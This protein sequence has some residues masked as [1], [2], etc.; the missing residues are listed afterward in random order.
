MG[1]IKI[2]HLSHIPKIKNCH[3]NCEKFSFLK[4]KILVLL[5]LFLLVSILHLR[6]NQFLF[7]P[8]ENVGLLNQN[9]DALLVN[10]EIEKNNSSTQKTKSTHELALSPWRKTQAYMF[11]CSVPRAPSPT[12]QKPTGSLSQDSQFT[13]TRIIQASYYAN[14]T[15]ARIIQ[16]S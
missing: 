15:T 6:W 13:S 16:A 14:Q 3:P 7:S 1:L 4:V 8:K 2:C 5:A 10:I 11:R 12:P 9:N